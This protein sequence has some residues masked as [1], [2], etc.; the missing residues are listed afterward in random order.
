MGKEKTLDRKLY[1]A[2]K[3]GNH[4]AVEEY[5]SKG[6]DPNAKV[7]KKG[8]SSMTR[9]AMKQDETLEDILHKKG[10][11]LHSSSTLARKLQLM[12]DA[13]EDGTSTF[14]Q[15]ASKP[16]ALAESAA[17]DAAPADDEASEKAKPQLSRMSSLAD[18][19]RRS[20]KR[21]NPSSPE[22]IPDAG[23][24]V[25]PAAVADDEDVPEFVPPSAGGLDMDTGKW[26]FARTKLTQT[27]KLGQG[28][29]GVVYAGEATGILPDEEMTR[30]AIKMLSDD[31]AA[32]T[33]D[34]MKEFDIMRAID[35]SDKIV[36]LL[37]VCTKDMPFCM[38]M[39]LMSRGDLKTVLRDNRPKAAKPSIFSLKQ[40]CLMAADVADGMAYLAKLKIVHRDLAARNCLVNDTLDVKIGDFGLTRDVY[41]GEY[42]R[43]TGSSPLPVRW[44]SPEA[45]AD[46]VYTSASDVWAFGIVLW[47][48]IT[49]AKMPYAGFSN[50]EVVDRVT[51]DEYRLPKPK[52]CPDKF[53]NFMLQCWYEDPELRSSFESIHTQLLAYSEELSDAPIAKLKKKASSASLGGA[54][55]ASVA[56]TYLEP[57]D[58]VA[59]VQ[60][61]STA[62]DSDEEQQVVETA[63]GAYLV[64]SQDEPEPELYQDTSLQNYTG[65]D[66]ALKVAERDAAVQSVALD[67]P[68]AKPVQ[69]TKVAKE[70]DGSPSP[71]PQ[72]ARKAVD[73]ASTPA[74]SQQAP[75]SSPAVNDVRS[76]FES[77]ALSEQPKAAAAAS[78]P[79]KKPTYGG[80]ASWVTSNPSKDEK[81]VAP[82][83]TVVSTSSAGQDGGRHASVV[84][85]AIKKKEEEVTAETSA[86][87]TTQGL[88]G[89]K[90]KAAPKY[91][92]ATSWV[93]AG[94]PMGNHVQGMLSASKEK[95]RTMSMTATLPPTSPK[96][97]TQPQQVL[98]VMPGIVPEAA[99]DSDR[100]ISEKNFLAN[101]KSSTATQAREHMAANFSRA[102]KEIEKWIESVIGDYVSGSSLHEVLKT[103]VVLC[104]LM[105]KIS[106]GSIPKFHSSSRLAF[107]QMENIGYFLEAAK[108]YGLPDSDLFITVDLFENSNM[109]QVVICLSALKKR[110]EMKGFR[111]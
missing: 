64:T 72:A 65:M 86:P 101:D 81:K 62:A 34:F 107:K 16:D 63:S 14:V 54:A 103:G 71:S 57:Q 96:T 89:K 97:P 70:Q 56:D 111:T 110:A 66:L 12:F 37:G 28:H 29:F 48:I 27:Q 44:M 31:S 105:R 83:A 45:I 60:S 21:K 90:K 9:A 80:A 42:Y 22:K 55:P 98:P 58:S 43:M 1:D 38:I 52:E 50:M 11:T 7:G 5:L 85:S 102:E 93:T 108:E 10:G 3:A 82:A 23:A 74:T 69:V 13:D 17:A 49:F 104:T 8:M 95:E 25:A 26:E 4:A 47:E 68:E 40:C 75:P 46:G 84:A 53:Y 19:V 32:A 106:P 39:E 6:A 78:A 73:A 88:F 91:G 36:R 76:R 24:I 41:S 77:A 15:H 61:P 94:T 99:Q 33:E 30:V 18:G 35:G 67:K 2:V 100:L 79:K 109:K 87:S 20:I 51:E 92:G 59:G